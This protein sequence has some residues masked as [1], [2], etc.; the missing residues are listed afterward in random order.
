MVHCTDPTPK[1]RQLERLTI[2]GAPARQYLGVSAFAE[3]MLVD[4]NSIIPIPDSLS[5]DAAALLACCITTGTATLFNVAR[6]HAGAS[7]AVFGCGGVGLGAIQA[8]RL[9]GATTVIAIDVQPHRLVAA[10]ALGATDTIDASHE[11]PIEAVRARTAGGVDRA[12]EAVGLPE[13]ASQAFAVLRP[14][15]TA[16]VLGMLPPNTEVVLP[17]R[18]LRQG[19]SIGGTVMGNVRTRADIPRY[20][21]L[22][23]SGGL[24]ADDLATA[25]YPLE[26]IQHAFDNAR[27]RRGIRTMLRF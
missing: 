10:A 20:I 24:K 15:G 19:R 21:N 22:V 23:T 14:G 1:Q 6:P 7:V 13:T 25:H 27:M 11:D 17:G 18:L 8:A 5:D 12:I 16:T 2:D 3:L 26:D 9:T 4:E